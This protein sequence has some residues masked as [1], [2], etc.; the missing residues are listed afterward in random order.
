MGFV[1]QYNPSK[2]GP[3]EVGVLVQNKDGTS[4]YNLSYLT[5]MEK[6]RTNTKKK[7]NVRNIYVIPWTIQ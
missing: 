3:M 5:V 1:V 2:F 6:F 7:K 4:S